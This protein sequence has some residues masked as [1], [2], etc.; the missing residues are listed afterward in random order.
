MRV[1]A[2]KHR[3]SRRAAAPQ[4]ASVAAVSTGS[5][6]EVYSSR[7]IP[8]F[9]LGSGVLLQFMTAISGVFSARILGVEG[10]G[11]VAL[12]VAVS[13][14]FSQLTLGGSF[15]TAVAQSVAA[16][17]TTAIDGLRPYR[18]RLMAWVALPSL[19]AGI[20]LAL[21]GR[22][23]VPH[24]VVE[25]AV[26]G[27]IMTAEAIGARVLVGCIQGEGNI[28]R[29][30]SAALMPQVVLTAAVVA[31]WILQKHTDAAELI[32]VAVIANAIAIG[33]IATMLKRSD[34]ERNRPLS[35]GDLRRRAARNYISSIGP[36]DGLGLDRNI[37]GTMMGATP[38]GLYAV[39]TAVAN[40]S[41][42]AGSA[43]GAILLTKV[44]AARAAGRSDARIV[45]EWLA[46]TAV[47]TAL[48]VVGVEALLP[49]IIKYA[50]GSAFSPALTTARW[51]VLADGLLGFRRALISVL[52]ARDL[53]HRASAIELAIAVLAVIGIIASAASMNLVAVAQVLSLAGLAACL[54]LA[55]ITLSSSSTSDPSER[56]PDHAPVKP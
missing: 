6:S 8:I 40:L 50:F 22:N 56:S 42:I 32:V 10:R 1:R 49:E 38:L 36:I 51:L 39:A 25:I 30:M 45:A 35:W 9:V 44:A 33:A 14:L 54:S 11:E 31:I 48:I 28:V 43:L 24:L 19:A 41:S 5:G 21:V 2:T 7:F 53:G 12:V 13:A 29:L 23:L 4:A 17:G 55:G 46:I 52:Q 16:A 20:Y 26:G 18:R 47:T 3:D 15:P 27:V 37:V 34:R